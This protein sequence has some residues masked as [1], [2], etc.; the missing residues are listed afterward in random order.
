MKY[1]KGRFYIENVSA[2]RIAKQFGT[3]SYVYSYDKIK[4]NI[5][6][7]GMSKANVTK[8]DMVKKIKKN[9]KDLKIN[10][11][12]NKKDPDKRDYYVSNK[13]IERKGFK[14]KIGIDQG[15]KEMIKVYKVK[16]DYKNNY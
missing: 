13:K 4:N 3:P 11:L 10:Y 5:Y 16:L 14:A 9:L 8:I 7:L 12:R 2:E 15:I 1:K 6:N